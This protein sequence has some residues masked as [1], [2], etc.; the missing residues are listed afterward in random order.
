MGMTPA[1]AAMHAPD[2]TLPQ[3]NGGEVRLADLKG[4]VVLLNFWATWCAPC[5]KEMPDLERLWRKYRER[6]L[7][8]LAISED[9]DA[10]KRVARFATKHRLSYPVL[11]DRDAKVGRQY[12]VSALPV[13]YLI[14]RGGNVVAATV[15]MKDWS[16]AQ[17]DALIEHLLR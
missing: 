14:D 11:L 2:F 17:A 6:G 7:M 1:P 3:S 16:G 5:R 13:S 10:D 15:G 8:V 9:A 12:E 4:K